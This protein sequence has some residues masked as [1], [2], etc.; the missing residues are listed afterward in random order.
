MKT[1]K[2]AH[3]VH[4]SAHAGGGVGTVLRALIKNS[5]IMGGFAH[6]LVTLESLNPK[7]SAWCKAHDVGFLEN[8]F[9]KKDRLF[10]LLNHADIVHIHWWNHP[11]L[12]SFLAFSP[13][14]EMRTVLW[15]HVNGLFAPQIFFK[16]IVDFPDI[17]VL[18]APF[19]EKSELISMRGHVFETN[20]AVIQSNAGL[21]E[22]NFQ[23]QAVPGR[24]RAGYVGTVDYSKMHKDFIGLWQDTR[25]KDYPLIVCGGPC[26]EKFRNQVIDKGLE[27]RFDIRGMVNNVPKVLSG[28]D[29]FF[30]PLNDTHYGTG[31]QVLIEAMASGVV[32]VVFDNPVE[33]YLVKDG[34]T[35]IIAHGK[36][37]FINGILFLKKHPDMLQAMSR[38][39]QAYAASSFDINHTVRQWHSLYSRLMEKNKTPHG[40]KLSLIEG[41]EPNSL[42]ALLFNA[43][44]DS[45]EGRT[46]KSLLKSDDPDIADKAKSLPPIFFSETRG[47]PFHYRNRL[48]IAPDLEK[49]C[50]KLKKIAPQKV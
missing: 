50:I 6:T 27:G 29:L 10:S 5:R 3:V 48:G 25:I 41:I 24:F 32:P 19:S 2:P 37:E 4:L 7:T 38:Q 15:A 30:Y 42:A 47:S 39:C 34:K 1:A 22:K 35:G 18:A 49:L 20:V 17:F 16:A 44:G 8:A 13:L 23:R 31:E 11:L 14:P 43:Y 28:L 46:L 36:E 26:E 40:L 12:H 21:P 45:M 9:Q 33:S